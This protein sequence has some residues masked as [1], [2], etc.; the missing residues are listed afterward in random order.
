MFMLSGVG[1][2][3]LV[4]VGLWFGKDRIGKRFFLG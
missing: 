1:G 2:L 3:G 4:W